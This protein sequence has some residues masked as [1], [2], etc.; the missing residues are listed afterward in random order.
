MVHHIVVVGAI[1]LV[2]ALHGLDQLASDPLGARQ[3]AVAD[4]LVVTKLETGQRVWAVC[5]RHCAR[6]TPARR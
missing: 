2:D 4:R 6:S 1:V 3:I 5:W